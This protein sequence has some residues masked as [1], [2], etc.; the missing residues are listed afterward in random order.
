MYRNIL[1]LFFSG[2]VLGSGPCLASCGPILI[3]YIIATKQKPTQSL[4]IWLLFS[5]SRIFVYLIL[6]VSIFFLGGFLVK[7]NLLYSA[8][9]IYPIGGVI[10]V[11]IGLFLIIRASSA[12]N[13]LCSIIS[14]RLDQRLL[15]L[16]PV[17]MGIILGLL[18][19][20]PLLAALSYIGL[21]SISWQS[22]IFYSLIFGLGTLI[23]PLILLALGAGSISKILFNK[24]K[25]HTILRFI[26]GLIIIVLGVLLILQTSH[27]QAILP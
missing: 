13:R 24:P 19:C 25:A 4:V 21:V 7:Q 23:S 17:T 5:L 20:M 16:Q 15:K 1:Y 11:F 9:Y 14:T 22:S 6:S 18:P 2:L 27:G 26:S 8:K 12:G 3:S 10:I